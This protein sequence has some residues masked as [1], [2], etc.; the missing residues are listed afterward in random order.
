MNR[1]P[2]AVTSPPITAVT[3]VDFRLHRATVIGEISSATAEERAP[4]Q[5][6]RDNRG[7]VET[8]VSNRAISQED[9]FI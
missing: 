6:E 7:E 1:Q 3:R 9:V 5:P 8:R 2:R 4:S